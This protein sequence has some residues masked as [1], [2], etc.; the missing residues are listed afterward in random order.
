MGRV[1]NDKIWAMDRW[2]VRVLATLFT[3]VAGKWKKVAYFF[4]FKKHPRPIMVILHATCL[5]LKMQRPTWVSQQGFNHWKVILLPLK[6]LK[7]F[8]LCSFVDPFFVDFIILHQYPSTDS[9]VNFKENGGFTFAVFS[10]RNITVVAAVMISPSLRESSTFLLQAELTIYCN[11][12][13]QFQMGKDIK[14]ANVI[15]ASN[16]FCFSTPT[17]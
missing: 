5:V 8:L 15:D 7:N 13:Y 3:A 10:A 17:S 2:I 1:F 16:A 6:G 4:K 12:I 9:T 14:I 11:R